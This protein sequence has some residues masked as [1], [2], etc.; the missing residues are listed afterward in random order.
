MIPTDGIARAFSIR[1]EDLAMDLQINPTN[2][3][4]AIIRQAGLYAYYVSAHAEAEGRLRQAKLERDVFTAALDKQLR[5]QALARGQKLTEKQV[6]MQ[7]MLHP[8]WKVRV[9]RV[10]ELEAAVSQLEGLVRAFAQKKDMLVTLA[11]NIRAE[12]QQSFA[13]RNQPQTPFG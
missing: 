8:D 11:T 7:V 10:N 13:I 5:D 3:D 12:R 1:P 9:Q 2:M 6:E 4:D